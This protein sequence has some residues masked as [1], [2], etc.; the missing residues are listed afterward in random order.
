MNKIVYSVVVTLLVVILGGCTLEVQNAIVEPEPQQIHLSATLSAP[1]Q[2]GTNPDFVTDEFG[3][4]PSESSG[5]FSAIL[6]LESNQLLDISLNVFGISIAELR[7]FGP[8][9]T[10]FHIHLPNSGNQGD[11][12]F[13]VIDLLFDAEEGS[14]V[15]TEN[16]FSFTRASHSILAGAQGKYEGAGVYPGDDVI[17]ELLQNGFPFILVHSSKD[18]F[19][20]TNGK[21]PNGD[22]VPVGFPFGELRGEISV[23]GAAGTDKIEESEVQQ[24]QGESGEEDV[25]LVTATATAEI[26]QDGRVLMHARNNRWIFDSVPPLGGPN[27]EVNPLDGIL[28]ALISCGMFI[29][30]AVG[31]E[32]GIEINNLSATVQGELDGRGVTGAPVNPR[33]RTFHITMNADGP[34]PDEAMMMAEAFS[35]RCPIYTTLARSADINVINVFARGRT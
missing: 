26:V 28:T 29:Y 33:I 8:N 31:I 17:A 22:P 21:F 10:P 6:D 11:F 9:A 2:N 35:T 23:D 12:G 24:I 5:E 27:E 14:L 34:T 4:V 7:N 20:N 3:V 15:D 18:I 25:Q 32:E 13:N 16:G 1:N 30:E 19:T